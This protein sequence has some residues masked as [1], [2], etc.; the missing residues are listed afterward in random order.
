MIKKDNY[1]LIINGFD[2]PEYKKILKGE[3]K[4]NYRFSIKEKLSEEAL[5]TF[6]ADNINN[7]LGFSLYSKLKLW[8]ILVCY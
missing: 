2:D 4:N 6:E 3:S 8:N 5:E 7:T 1:R